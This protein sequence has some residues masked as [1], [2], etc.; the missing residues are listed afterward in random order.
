LQPVHQPAGIAFKLR[1]ARAEVALNAY[2]S[3]AAGVAV[4]GAIYDLKVGC[5][6]VQTHFEVEGHSNN[7]AERFP[8]LDVKDP[9]RR[10]P[11]YGS[12]YPLPANCVP[13]VQIVPVRGDQV[14]HGRGGQGAGVA[15]IVSSAD[16]LDIAIRGNVK[17]GISLVVEVHRER[18]TDSRDRV[19][20]VVAGIDGAGNDGAAACGNRIIANWASRRWRCCRR[21]RWRPAAGSDTHVIQ[22]KEVGHVVEYELEVG[23][24]S[25]HHIEKRI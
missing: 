16:E 3:A 1:R 20:I 12:E 6:L 25:G 10:S 8:E 19:V 14:I 11:R 21:W 9:V 4:Q 23:V 18:Q 13:I 7:A 5:I 22:V 15:K 24:G 17:R 2:S